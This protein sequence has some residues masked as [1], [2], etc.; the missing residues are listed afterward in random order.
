A[1]RAPPGCGHC[2]P[3]DTAHLGR[4]PLV[5]AGWR[6]TPCNRPGGDLCSSLS[7][8]TAEPA[9]DLVLVK[10]EPFGVPSDELVLAAAPEVR[11]RGGAGAA[12]ALDA[13]EV[14]TL[15]LPYGGQHGGRLGA[16]TDAEQPQ[17]V[18]PV[19]WLGEPG[20]P[21]ERVGSQRDE[22]PRRPR[23]VADR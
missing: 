12:Q 1:R 5:R 2:R 22:V 6:P 10:V 9:D 13:V 18:R 20:T 21:A 15:D 16:V 8:L 14:V 17:A 23:Q 7:C 4:V 19:G 3:R 11:E